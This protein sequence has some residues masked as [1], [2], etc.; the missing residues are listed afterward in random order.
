MSESKRPQLAPEVIEEPSTGETRANHN[1]EPRSFTPDTTL[2]STEQVHL[3]KAVS[4]PIVEV[5][6]D[7]S[8]AEAHRTEPVR[9]ALPK[10]VVR[11]IV[12][13]SPGDIPPAKAE[14]QEPVRDP[15]PKPVARPIVE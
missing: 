14:A 8:A 3:S 15:L 6:Q 2:V 12:E 5:S 9:E 7:I 1:K 4:R 13:V 10:A 11:P